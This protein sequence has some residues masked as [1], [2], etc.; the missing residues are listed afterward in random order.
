M[1]HSAGGCC[2]TFVRC[3]VMFSTRRCVKPRRALVQRKRSR[4]FCAT[5]IAVKQTQDSSKVISRPA[6]T[7][8]DKTK[9]II[10]SSSAARTIRSEE[11]RVGKEGRTQD[12]T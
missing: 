2:T 1:C 7:P 5:K 3:A 11:R 8:H 10:N 4:I 6:E 9:G 12:G